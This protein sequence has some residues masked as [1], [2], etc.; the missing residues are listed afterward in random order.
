MREIK[1]RYVC[2]HKE[3]GRIITKVWNIEDIEGQEFI[4]WICCDIRRYGLVARNLFTGLHDK[5]GKE[6]YEGDIV[7]LSCEYEPDRK[8]IVEFVDGSFVCR[9]IKRKWD[10]ALLSD[11]LKAYEGAVVIGNIYENSELLETNSNK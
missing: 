8:G 7:D 6:I 5:N 10:K 1:F 3:T 2:Q 9:S 11:V 4:D